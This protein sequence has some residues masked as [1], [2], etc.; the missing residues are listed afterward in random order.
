MGEVI[1]GKGLEVNIK[2][3]VSHNEF[4]LLGSLPS[5][6]FMSTLQQVCQQCKNLYEEIKLNY[7]E[8]SG[9]GLGKLLNPF[10]S[11]LGEL[12]F[13]VLSFNISSLKITGLATGLT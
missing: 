1:F 3:G 8:T 5:A 4:E 10:F 13:R 2:S 7:L 11:C 12:R 9:M 6:L